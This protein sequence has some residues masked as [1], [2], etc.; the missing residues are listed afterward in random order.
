MKKMILIMVG[1]ILISNFPQTAKAESLYYGKIKSESVYF[2]DEQKTQLFL[3]P[4][5]YFVQ[6]FDVEDE[7]YKVNYKDLEGYVKKEDVTLM[8][9][10]P[11]TPFFDGNFVNYA[12]FDLYEKPNSSSSILESFSENQSFDYYGTI[13]GEAMSELTDE[14]FYCSTKINGQTLKGYIYAG[15]VENKPDLSLNTEMFEEISE[16]VFTA[17]TNGKE[18]SALSTGTKILLIISIAVP[19]VFILYFLIKPTKMK[20]Q[21]VEK[22]GVRKIQHGDY[23]EYDEKDL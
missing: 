9:G 11:N 15:V 19:S 2:Y 18:F 3:L 20:K 8:D 17:T 23:F 5:S 4:Y 6:V 22:K 16:E 12:T 13:I 14:W 1:L 7:F 21:K 10:N